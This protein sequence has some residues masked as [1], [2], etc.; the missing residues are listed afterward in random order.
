MEVH[1]N[2]SSQKKKI[3]K[4][5]FIEKD[6]ENRNH[7]IDN[8]L[9]KIFIEGISQRSYRGVLLSPLSSLRMQVVRIQFR[10]SRIQ[11]VRI[12]LSRSRIQIGRIQFSRSRIQ[13]VRYSLEGL[14][15]KQLGYSLA[16]LG[17]KQLGYSLA[18]LGYIQLGYS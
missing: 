15:Y 9:Q 1:R 3:M 16:G 5:K 17:Y 2:G 8:Y 11:I 12:Q 6:L 10:R 4:K 18:G 13:I 14:G 7:L